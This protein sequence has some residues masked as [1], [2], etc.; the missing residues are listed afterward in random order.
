MCKRILIESLFMSTIG[1]RRDVLKSLSRALAYDDFKLDYF[2]FNF[3]AIACCVKINQRVI[4]AE[5]FRGKAST[6]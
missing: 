5:I 3:T 2:A 4:Y 1:W 6:N